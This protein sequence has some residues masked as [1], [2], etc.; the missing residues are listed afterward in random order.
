MTNRDRGLVGGLSVALLVL[1]VAALAPTVEPTVEAGSQPSAIPG[2][3]PYVEGVLGH[4]TNASPF[5]ARSPADRALVALLFRGL[6]R[7]GPGGTLVPD[8]AVRW[9]S[10]PS[11]AA[12]TFHLRPG[13]RWQD[14]EPLTAADVVFTVEALSAA[15]YA[16]PGAASWR[17]VI[18]TASDP[19]TVTL[20]LTTPLGGFLQAATQ[21]IAPAHLLAQVSPADLPDDPFGRHPIGSGAFTLTFLDG[22]RAILTATT[23]LEPPPFEE[24]GPNFATPR[25][26]DSLGTPAP[27]ARPRE[28]IPYLTGIEFVFYDDLAGILAA[29]NRGVLDAIS[30][31]SPAEATAL[32]RSEG[33]TL[34]QYPG[35]TLLAVELDLRTARI[36]FRDPAV[37]RALLA[38]IGRD[39]VVADVLAGL[40]TRADSLIPPTSALFDRAAS[41]PVAYD[42]TAAKAAL[43]AAGWKVSGGSWVPKGAKSPLVIEVLSPED[44]ANP[45]AHAVAVAVVAAWRAIGL[46]A[47]QIPLPAAELLGERLRPGGF[48]A[49]VV[50][51]VI[52]LDPDLYPLLASTQTRTG[53]SNVSGLQDPALDKLLAAA[54]AP[55]SDAARKAAYAALETRLAAG[56]FILPIA[57]RN[58]YVVLRDTVTGPSSR[59][60]GT[61]GDRFW[62]VLTWRLADGR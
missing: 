27:T 16:G 2:S 6:V 39:V 33:A 34:L 40:G 61:S 15:D 47:R 22:S 14:G 26:T 4:A 44:T 28:A 58:E 52:G 21:S 17:E 45:V 42:P 18:A 13:M 19:L 35:S 20:R 38:A 59:A 23:A 53:G 32:G 3:R 1:C 10:D 29:W 24:G 56:A 36:E 51:L 9:E 7:L 49:A 43:K 8:L 31:L 46:D 57:F 25:P 60:I 55:G 30:G 12:W 54:R 50:P 62:D 37:R 48:Q 5:G 11:G 41:P